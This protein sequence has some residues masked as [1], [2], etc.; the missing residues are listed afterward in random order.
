MRTLPGV[1]P[2]SN[3][4]DIGAALALALKAFAMK[5]LASLPSSPNYLASRLLFC[6]DSRS[7]K[8]KLL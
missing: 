2:K 5:D 7:R 3:S 1:L 4:R 8:G 6:Y